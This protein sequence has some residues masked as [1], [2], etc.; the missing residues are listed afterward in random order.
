MKI[1]HCADFHITC[2]HKLLGEDNAFNRAKLVLDSLHEVI[3]EEE[4]DVV[5]II[6]DIFN[7]DEPDSDELFLFNEWLFP[8]LEEGIDVLIIPGNHD[9]WA[10]GGK[11]GVDFIRPMGEH[12]S[13]LYIALRGVKVVNIRDVAFI[14]WPWGILPSREDRTLFLGRNEK[15]PKKRIGLLHTALKN[16][17]ISGDG[18]ILKKGFSVVN[19][20]KTLDFLNLSYLLLGDIHEYQ[21]FCKNK[22]IYS[23]ALY[24][25]KFGEGENKGVV[26]IDT[27]KMTH[28]F[29]ELTGVPKLREIDRLKD[30]NAYD[31]FK[32]KAT[33]KEKAVNILSKKLPPN[34]V[35]VE[36]VLKRQKKEEIEE[37]SSKLGLE[38]SLVPIIVKI[39]KKQGVED[40]RGAIKYLASLAESKEDFVLP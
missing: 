40:I 25:T 30:I 20:K 4:P 32:F 2:L 17:R 22:V 19:A 27:D 37:A 8:I 7:S 34:V 13:N 36:H 39:L 21:T 1:L 38:I 10:K 35:K 18:R 15:R 29:V 5:V 24:Q 14:M 12:L 26:V 6:G 16:S 9:S 33:S 31:F 23:G 28:R 11:T 3:W